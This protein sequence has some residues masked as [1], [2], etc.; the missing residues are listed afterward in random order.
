MI[1]AKVLNVED[2][3]VEYEEFKDKP[4]HMAVVLLFSSV[5]FMYETQCQGRAKYKDRSWVDNA[6]DSNFGGRKLSEML[7]NMNPVEIVDYI[8]KCEGID[9][10]MMPWVRQ[11][12]ANGLS[13]F[14]TVT[15]GRAVAW[16]KNYRAPAIKSGGVIKPSFVKGVKYPKHWEVCYEALMEVFEAQGNPEPVSTGSEGGKGRFTRIK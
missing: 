10:L 16:A 6:L 9:I 15:Q 4:Y 8:H 12:F 2:Y 7:E 3:V 14:S 13:E 5:G 11:E 1:L